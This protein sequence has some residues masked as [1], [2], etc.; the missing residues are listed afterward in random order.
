MRR[1]LLAALM[2]ST[3]ACGGPTSAAN[4]TEYAADIQRQI[5][6]AES[7]EELLEWLEAT[8]EHAARL[9]HGSSP[10]AGE[11]CVAAL[12]QAMFA[13]GAMELEGLLDIAFDE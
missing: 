10:A 2:L 4:C 3:A 9:I 13:A 1:L 11:Q 7:P 5:D 8:S 12:L 6:A